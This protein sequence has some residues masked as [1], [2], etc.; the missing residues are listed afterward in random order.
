M[1]LF[2]AVDQGAHVLGEAGTA[3]T[4]AGVDEVVADARVGADAQAHR[5]DVGTQVFG[6]LGDLVDEADLGRQHAVGGVFGQLGTAQIHE[7]D[8]FMVA[9]ERR[10]EVTHHVTHVFT[11]TT[12]DDTVRTPAIGNGRA[13]LE[14]FGV[15]DDIELQQTPDLDQAPVD[16]RAQGI[17]G[18]HRH[19]GFLH[20]D[21][22]LLTV[23]SHR[24]AHRHH[25]AQVGRAIV[26][27]RCADCDEQ[28]LAMLHR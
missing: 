7:H 4:A 26:P 5:F 14:K 19:G 13:F 24:F 6:Q 10:V 11:L 25:M 17:A 9:V 20:Q 15:G 1:G 8:A 23:P 21:H 27:G 16:M 22:R 28:H 18:T 3:I 2:G 12:H